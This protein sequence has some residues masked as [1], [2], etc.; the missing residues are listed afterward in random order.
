[1]VDNLMRRIL[2]SAAQA[3][4]R[5][6]ATSQFTGTANEFLA[7]ISAQPTVVN[8]YTSWCKPC[9]AIR[10][11]YEE[12]AQT[13]DPAHNIQFVN[14]NVEECEEV[15]ALHD[16][17]SI[18]TFIAFRNGDVVGRVEGARIEELQDMMTR[19]RKALSEPPSG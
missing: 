16:I 19:L 11:Q 3:T 8:F 10:G 4:G 12:L 17:R 6:V 9:S 14:L 7:S 5:K 18:P 2:I 15:S 1:M 13:T